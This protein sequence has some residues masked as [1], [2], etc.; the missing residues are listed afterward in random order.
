MVLPNVKCSSDPGA[1]CAFGWIVSDVEYDA[2]GGD[3]FLQLSAANTSVTVHMGSGCQGSEETGCDVHC[4]LVW[5]R[6][7]L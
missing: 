4:T 1:H 3:R 7:D 2:V 5:R 6:F